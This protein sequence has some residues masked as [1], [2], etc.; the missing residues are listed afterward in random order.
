MAL[1]RLLFDGGSERSF[2]STW[3][4]DAL[5]LPV[6]GQ[7]TLVIKT[8]GSDQGTLQTC[9]I[10]QFCVRSPYNDLNIYVNAYVTPVVCAPLRNQATE[11]AASSYAHLASL[12]LADF[13]VV[14]EEDLIIDILIGSNYYWLFLSS[15]S[16]RGEDHCNGPVALDSRLGWILSGPVGGNSSVSSIPMNLMQ[17]HAMRVDT[18][19]MT[20]EKQLSKF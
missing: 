14:G 4:K 1:A 20:L 18:E 12:P 5:A 13:P 6:I 3:L 15:M 7:E 11:F 19:E 16:I 9:D 2:V 8:F 10:V 17:T